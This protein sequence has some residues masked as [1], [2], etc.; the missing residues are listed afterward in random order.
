MRI[1]GG[2]V[3]NLE[4]V[5]AVISKYTRNWGIERINNID[6]NILRAAVY[7]LLYCPDIP[8]KVSINE[9]IEVGK[10]Y[11]TPDSGKFI[12][13]ILD[14]IAKE[15]EKETGK[16]TGKKKGKEKGTDEKQDQG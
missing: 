1:C 13:G 8:Y 2:V 6:R 12:N 16:E 7:E 14:K 3:K 9:A 11:G 4:A 5:D 15:T 10:K